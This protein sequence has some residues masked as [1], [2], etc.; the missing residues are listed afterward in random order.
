MHVCMHL[1]VYVSTND[2]ESQEGASDHLELE[3]QVLV[4]GLTGALG[5]ESS[6]R[7]V[8]ALNCHAVL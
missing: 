1:R 4:T 3:C 7:E 2:L 8:R 6:T 5:T